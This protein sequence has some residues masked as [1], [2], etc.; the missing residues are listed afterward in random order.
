LKKDNVIFL[1]TEKDL[2]DEANNRIGRNLTDEEIEIAKDGFEWGL[3]TCIL[4]VTYN[5]I[6]TEMI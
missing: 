4:D 1:V 6:F 5:T 3:R 2:Q